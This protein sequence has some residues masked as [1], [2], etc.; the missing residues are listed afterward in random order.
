MTT[1]LSA[2]RIEL[3]KL[4]E[5]SL[6]RIKLAS[7]KRTFNMAMVGKQLQVLKSIITSTSINMVYPLA[8]LEKSTNRFFY[9]KAMF[10]NITAKIGIGVFRLINV[11]ITI[12][13]HPSPLPRWTLL[14]TFRSSA[15]ATAKAIWI[16]RRCIVS[17]V[18]FFTTRFTMTN[19][20]FTI[21]LGI[22][23]PSLFQAQVNKGLLTPMGTSKALFIVRSMLG[24]FTVANNTFNH[25]TIIP[26]IPNN[27]KGVN[28]VC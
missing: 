18:K 27:V 20:D 17:W 14:T 24:N 9:Y 26:L 5:G 12:N 15:L 10:T 3:S 6:W 25:T 21:S 1:A 7:T 13:H 23:I 19:R 4:N 22:N 16:A 2:C 8:L 11:N 28:Y